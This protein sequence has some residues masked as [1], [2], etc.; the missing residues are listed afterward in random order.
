[1]ERQLASIQT[2]KDLQ[3]I[4]GADK[5]EVATILGWKVVVRKGEFKIGDSCIYFEIDSILPKKDWS[6]F[7]VDKNR[8]DKPI[9]LKTIRLRG[10]ISQGLAIPITLIPDIGDITEGRDVTEF[11]G[12]EKYEPYI[13]AQLAG[14]TRGNFPSYLHKTDETR[15]QSD[16]RLIKEFANKQVYVSVKVDGS[17]VTISHKDGDIQVCS[18]NLSLKE[19]DE[20]T[21]WK[22]AKQYDIINK[23]IEIYNKTRINYAIQGEVYGEGIQKNRLGIKGIKLALFNVF[24]INEG[25]FLSF[26]DFKEFCRQIDVPTVPIIYEGMFIWGSVEELLIEAQGTYENGHPREGIVIRPINEFYSQYLRSRASFKVINNVFLE[27]IGE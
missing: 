11:L 1:M 3:P 14:I 7:L 18:R 8:P 2:I 23:L 9:R 21:Y 25:R 22:I 13:P 4:D 16:P 10:Q 26:D 17:S 5:I 12:I 24:N 6:M 27:K 19:D 20:N 15:I